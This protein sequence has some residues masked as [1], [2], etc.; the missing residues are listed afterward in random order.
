MSVTMRKVPRTPAERLV[1][2]MIQVLCRWPRAAVVIGLL[3][4]ALLA[5]ARAH[6]AAAATATWSATYFN[7]KT[8]TGPSVLARDD[9][10]N[11]DFAWAGS[12]GPGVNADNFSVRWTRTIDFVAGV[13]EFSTVSDDGAR[14]FLDGSAT[15]LPLDAWYDQAP[16]AHSAVHRMTAGPH[17]VTVE[18]YDAAGGAT[19]HFWLTRRQELDDFA[20]QTVATAVPYGTTVFAFAPDGRI[21]IGEQGGTV[22]IYK[23]GALL[24]TPF[25]QIQNVNTYW[26]HGLLGMALDPNFGSNGYVYLSF[27][28]ENDPTNTTG[29]KNGRIIRVTAS[30]DTA[31]PGSELVLAGSRVGTPAKPSCEQ[32]PLTDDCIPSDS[33]SHSV[34]ALK[35]GPDG[36]LYAATGD[37]AS[38]DYVDVLALRAQNKDRLAG[39][40]LRLN[41]ANGQGLAD[42]PFCAPGCDLTATRSRVWAYGVRNDF[43]FNFRPGTN[44]IFSGDVGWYTTEE[45]DAFGAGANLGWPCW[46][47][48]D[49]NGNTADP[50]TYAGMSVCQ[51]LIAAGGDTK[52]IYTYAHPGPASA[53]GGSFSGDNPY[54]LPFKNAFFWGDYSRDQIH[55]LKVDAYNQLVA[56]S[57]QLFAS[58]ADGAVQF[59]TGPDGNIYYLSYNTGQLRRIV[60]TGYSVGGIAEAPQLPMTAPAGRGQSVPSP[61]AIIAGGFLGVVVV[62]G[63]CWLAAARRASD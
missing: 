28:Y 45:I 52:P 8:L 14:V 13:Y 1:V 42:N 22:V 63:G 16:T 60:Y 11:I 56:G 53:V 41:P 61:W 29:P 48:L 19:I 46:E 27:T 5:P 39:K 23:N 25:Y 18:F 33:A 43:R 24:P 35:F 17:V 50:T 37:G 21:F 36:K 9:G 10:A 34:G 54:S 4:V 47:G 58:D 59:E 57:E 40:I 55:V 51:A 30:G 32:W 44:T 20:T 49:W 7:N 26:D 3:V 2:H 31:V 62:G 6:H 12:P 38:F 15:A